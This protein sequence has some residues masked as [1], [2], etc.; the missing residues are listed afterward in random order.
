MPMPLTI[1]HLLKHFFF[2]SSTQVL[3]SLSNRFPLCDYHWCRSGNHL[4]SARSTQPEDMT[5][6]YNN[7]KQSHHLCLCVLHPSSNVLG[8]PLRDRE[9]HPNTSSQPIIKIPIISKASF[10]PRREQ[11][12]VFH[13]GP[14]NQPSDVFM[15]GLFDI[16]V[17]GGKMMAHF[18]GGKDLV[19]LVYSTQS[20]L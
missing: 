9:R 14:L 8:K 2:N 19:N 18:R 13:S 4:L 15:T 10:Y 16:N 6:R 20:A 12:Q 1:P 5:D 17:L 7:P 3:I 11:W